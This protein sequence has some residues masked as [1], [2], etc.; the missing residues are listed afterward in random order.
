MQKKL[1]IK[2]V[3]GGQEHL[4]E[5]SLLTVFK[6][7]DLDPKTTCISYDRKLRRLY[8]INSVG[9]ACWTLDG[10]QALETRVPTEDFCVWNGAQLDQNGHPV[11][12]QAELKEW[13][14]HT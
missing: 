2:L 6:P 5:G 1:K 4:V 14:G 9:A 7:K 10:I 12:W 3:L 11:F 13:P 8:Y